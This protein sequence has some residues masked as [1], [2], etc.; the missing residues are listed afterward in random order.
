MSVETGHR[1]LDAVEETTR[2][3]GDVL[4]WPAEI[5]AREIEHYRARV[6][7][8]IDSQRQ[9]DDQTADAARMDAPDVRTGIAE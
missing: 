5:R 1:G 6:A 9:P 7:A 2:L 3:M 8:E 4:G